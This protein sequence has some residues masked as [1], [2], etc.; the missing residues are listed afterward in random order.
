MRYATYDDGAS[1]NINSNFQQLYVLDPEYRIIKAKERA[2]AGLSDRSKPQYDRMMKTFMSSASGSVS[3]NLEIEKIL[4]KSKE[5]SG[6]KPGG[7]R[8][9]PMTL[10][11]YR[12]MPE[13]IYC[14]VEKIFCEWDSRASFVKNLNGEM[15]IQSCKEVAEKLQNA[16]YQPIGV[17]GKGDFVQPLKKVFN[18][19]FGYILL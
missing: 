9:V 2:D 12:V 10:I 15:Y 7:Y 5:Y 18:E 1:V 19:R 8:P 14:S 4:H 3:Y 13:H 11:A 16:G 17:I 6:S